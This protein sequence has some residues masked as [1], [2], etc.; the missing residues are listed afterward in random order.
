[1]ADTVTGPTILS[2]NDNRVTIKIVVQ[3][4]K[5]KSAK[6]LFAAIKDNTNVVVYKLQDRCSRLGTHICHMVRFHVCC[7]K[8]QNTPSDS[9]EQTLL[10]VSNQLETERERRKELEEQYRK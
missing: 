5:T 4:D 7:F 10:S 3:S 8:F 2:Q 9:L 1:M 6:T